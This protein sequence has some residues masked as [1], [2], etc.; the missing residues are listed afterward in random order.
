MRL[1]HPASSPR[2]GAFSGDMRG[3]P[4]IV[5]IEHKEQARRSF[6]HST[7]ASIDMT[8]SSSDKKEDAAVVVEVTFV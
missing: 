3:I 1:R 7:I 2:V 4:G 5:P 8:G 6:L